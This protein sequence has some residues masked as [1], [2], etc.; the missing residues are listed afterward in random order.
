[1]AELI[2]C[3]SR[4]QREYIYD[5]LRGLEHIRSLMN[6]KGQEWEPQAQALRTYA[7]NIADVL[8]ALPLDPRCGSPSGITE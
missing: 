3:I 1:M 2:F 5:S 4:E 6:G 7:E 8:S